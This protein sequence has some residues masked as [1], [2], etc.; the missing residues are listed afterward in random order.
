MGTN[1]RMGKD[2]GEKVGKGGGKGVG[3]GEALR[4]LLEMID[5]DM[6]S[7]YKSLPFPYRARYTPIVRELRS[8]PLMVGG[9]S[10]KLSITQGAVSQSIRLM[11]ED[12][13]I[14]KTPGKDARQSFIS[15]SEKGQQALALLEPHWQ[16][17]H[18]AIEQLEKDTNTPIMNDLMGVMAQLKKQTFS[19][20]VAAEKLKYQLEND[21][22][23][24]C[25][26]PHELNQY[27]TKDNAEVIKNSNNW[28]SLESDTYRGA[29]PSYPAS[30]AKTLAGLCEQTELAIDV[31]CGSGQ[32]SA[33]LAEQFQQVL[34]LDSSADQISVAKGKENIQYK[35]SGAEQ[36]HCADTCADLIVAA[37]AAHWFDLECFYKEVNRVAKP[38]ATLAL[39]S[40]GVP[41]IDDPINSIFQQGYWQDCFH[42]WPAQRRPVENGY[43]QLYF[44]FDEIDFPRSNI[45][46][47]MTLEE[48][49]A[50]I[51][52]WSAYKVAAKKDQ[53]AAFNEWFSRLE[54]QWE[55]EEKKRVLWPIAGRVGR[56]T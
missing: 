3:I 12:G 17:I 7:W 34:A 37:Q 46:L 47:N 5:G 29:R 9:L 27:R 22:K 20:R 43:S 55:A 41:Y 23:P 39:I 31:G 40:Y 8:G 42:F 11:L 26:E 19:E 56:L 38:G 1:T 36:L 18:L 16:S 33:V 24:T 2:I 6:D 21:I 4:Q 44:P 52:T 25:K 35:V 50:Y 51:S 49:L 48:F 14:E 53:L 54:Q 30:L 10:Q 13:L 28:F 32:L 45:E 15:L